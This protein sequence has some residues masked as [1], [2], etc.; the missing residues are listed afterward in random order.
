MVQLLLKRGAL[1]DTANQHGVTPRDLAKKYGHPK[2][3]AEF[4]KWDQKEHRRLMRSKKAKIVV[5]STSAAAAA[6]AA[7]D[8]SEVEMR[9]SSDSE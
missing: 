1:P 2:V 3:L 7:T 4:A 8:G 6:A 9:S 5:P